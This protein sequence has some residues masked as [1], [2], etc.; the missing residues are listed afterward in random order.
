MY[1]TK[2]Y[3]YMYLNVIPR[4]ALDNPTYF[5][6]QRSVWSLLL[7]C[8]LRMVA[9]SS[10]LADALGLLTLTGSVLNSHSAVEILLKSGNNRA[11]V[12]QL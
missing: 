12:I 5:K 3:K 1:V 11:N 2:K 6:L 7:R 10:L 4:M 9:K 8:Y